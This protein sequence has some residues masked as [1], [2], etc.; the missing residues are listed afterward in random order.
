MA[1]DFKKSVRTEYLKTSF[2]GFLCGLHGFLWELCG[3]G[4]ANFPT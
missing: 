1:A 3:K 2:T 4:F